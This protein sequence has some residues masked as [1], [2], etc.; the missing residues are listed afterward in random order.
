MSSWHSYPSVFSLGHKAISELL[1]D[2]VIVEEKIDGS[3]INFGRFDGVLKIKSHHKEME[4]NAP[5]K[6]FASAVDYIKMLPLH[7]G[8]TYR[9]ECL[10]KPKHNALCYERIPC[11]G[12]ILFDIN[13]D[14]ESYLRYDEKKEEAER[15]G[16]EIV[17]IFYQGR[18]ESANDVLGF[19]DRVSILGGQKIEG[20]VI[21]NY[22]RF[23]QDKKVLMGKYVSEGFKEVHK[24]TWGEANPKQ[25]DIVLRLIGIYKTSARWN[26]AILHMSEKGELENSPR[27][28]GKLINEVKADIKKECMEEI[29][30]HLFNWAIDGI[31]RGA[32]GGLAEWYKKELLEK[33][34]EGK[35][36]INDE[37]I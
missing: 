27:D 23:G 18:I 25:G 33:Q 29:K 31:L 26:K 30:E 14:E 36:E 10:A 4:P 19:L 16:L 21:K 8:W 24:K 32:T 3:Q 7:D 11:G 9:G 15:I 17:P 2:P 20:V 6:M 34:F 35:G 22:T 37:K 13:K 28:I 12:V 1:L 5:E